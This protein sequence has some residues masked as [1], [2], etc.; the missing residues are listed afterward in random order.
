VT[1]T[2]T[3]HA[4]SPDS[5]LHWTEPGA[6][7]V[8][9][10]VHRIPLPL[11]M[12]GLR[13]VNVYALETEHGLTLVDGGWAI[14]ESRTLLEKSLGD[15]GF[16]LSDI[17][18]FLVTHVHRDHYTQAAVIGR[19]YGA[20]VSLGL[21]DKPTL[22]LMHDADEVTEDPTL[23]V[24]RSAGAVEIAREWQKFTD[25]RLPDLSVWG[26]PDTW[27]DGDHAIEVGTRTLDAVHTP[28]HTQGHYVF[29]DR[30]AGLLFAGDHVLPTITPSIGFEPVPV[31]QPLRDFLGSLTKVRGL[32]DLRL[33]P[34]HGPV[35]PSSHAR[36]DQLLA[37]HE[38]RLRL[39]LA[40]LEA[41]PGTGHDVASDLPWTQHQHSLADLD[42]FNAAL[43][44]METKAH[45]ELLVARGQATREATT[46][47][48][49]FSV[50]PAAG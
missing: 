17:T 23:D 19:E 39:C 34:A 45:L 21:G 1:S 48:V 18:R 49:V 13:A 7:P 30:P 28:G 32:P 14:E 25:G 20:H 29:A 31:E 22:D 5:G 36:V 3:A 46:D 27:L 10:G 41:R 6:W 37:H 2:D 33:L 40:S 50:L 44:S 26:Y 47:G 42:V 9:D 43:A 8:A 15:V 35:A 24:L 11:P 12:D 38:E 16:G 4:V